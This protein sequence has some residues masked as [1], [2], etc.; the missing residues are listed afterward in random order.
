MPTGLHV[1]YL[2][3]LSDCNKTTV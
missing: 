1:K 2:L 3:F